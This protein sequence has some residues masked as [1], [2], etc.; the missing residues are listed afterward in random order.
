MRL[1]RALPAPDEHALA[2]L[3]HNRGGLEHARGHHR[4]G[5][6]FAR[7]GI[8]VRLAALGPG[9]EDVARDFAALGALL[10]GQ[11][12][13]SEA[14]ECH[15][16]ALET[17]RHRPLPPRRDIAAA[18]GNLAA[19]LHEQGR[20]IEAVSLGERGLAMSVRTLGRHHPE[21][22]LAAANLALMRRNAGTA[23]GRS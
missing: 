15:R 3:L 1:L 22:E 7:R 19:C 2:S 6:V 4:R 9:H 13:H 17:F 8:A 18:L 23:S 5:E 12:R 21:A 14:E 16:R 20:S 11:R 10:D